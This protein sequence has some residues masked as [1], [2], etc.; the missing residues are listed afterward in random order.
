MKQFFLLLQL[1]GSLSVLAQDTTSK[2][3]WGAFTGVERNYR[4]LNTPF[5]EDRDRW[6]DAEIPV[7][8]IV[9]GLRFERKL[10]NRFSCTAGMMYADRG[11]QIDSIPEASIH[12]LNF[13]YRYVEV[14]IG[15]FYTTPLKGKNALLSGVTAAIAYKL[16]DAVFY[17]KDGQTAQFEMHAGQFD[18][19]AFNVSAMLGVRRAISNTANLD[20]YLNGTQSLIGI[21]S[22]DYIRRLNAV[23]IFL[24][25]SN[26]F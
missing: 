14:P 12:G 8:R 25:I 13:H 1:I 24:A 4:L 9:G 22:G 3:S 10:S 20:V 21:A 19:T 2:W 15:I 7:N 6:N 11:Y 23:G 5:S 16:S 17:F 18:R 26:H